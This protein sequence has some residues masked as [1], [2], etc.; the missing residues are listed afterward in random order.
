MPNGKNV[1][2]W[3]VEIL[4]AL[5]RRQVNVDDFPAESLHLLYVRGYT[6]EQAVVKVMQLRASG[7]NVDSENVPTL[8]GR[9]DVKPVPKE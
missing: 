5:Q 1:M 7:K 9:P 8:V 2:R 6:V 3:A 4:L